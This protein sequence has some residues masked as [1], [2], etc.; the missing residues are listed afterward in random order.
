[1]KRDIPFF[2]YPQMFLAHEAELSQVVLDVLRRGAYILQRDLL[3]FEADL[4]RYL[5]VKHAIGVADGTMGLL[6]GLMAAGIEAGDEVLVPSHTFVASAAAVHFAGATP[7]LV[8]CGRD[9]LMDPASAERAMTPRTRAIMPVHLNGRCTAMEPLLALAQREGLLIVEDACQALGAR[10]QGRF[11]GTFG[12]FGA[13][14]F[15][16]A[17]TLGAFGDAGALVTDDDALAERVRLLRDHGR[18]PD[19]QVQLWGFNAR[20]DN[21]QAA[22]LKFKLARYDQD[23]QRRREIAAQ[24]HQRL[25]EVPGLLLPPGP[26]EDPRHFDVYQNYEIEAERRDALRAHLEAHGVRTILQWGGHTIHQ[27]AK[28]GL[29]A[30]VPYTER[31]TGRFLML[32][33]HTALSDDDVAYICD[34]IVAFYAAS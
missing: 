4:A 14:S 19:G 3:E 12:A 15:Y 27:F 28:L 17:K 24:Y 25:K 11:A 8:D 33:L 9:H 5:G 7:V 16:P 10:Y 29:R 21:V 31:M 30:E 6:L 1:M 20:L 32:P 22:V 2:P 26:E 23:V 18:G 13:F 34:R